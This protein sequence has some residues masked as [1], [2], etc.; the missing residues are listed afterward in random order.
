MSLSVVSE[1][2]GHRMVIIGALWL[3]RRIV[4][5]TQQQIAIVNPTIGNQPQGLSRVVVNSTS[6]NNQ[7]PELNL[8]SPPL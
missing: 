4:R 8:T 2:G 7:L 1:H 3:V 5:I 6:I